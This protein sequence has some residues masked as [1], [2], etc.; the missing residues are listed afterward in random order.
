MQNLGQDRDWRRLF[1]G[2]APSAIEWATLAVGLVLTLRYRWLL[3]DAF[4]YFRYIDNLLFLKIGLVYNQGEFVE[5]F[6]SPLWMLTLL[7]GR[8]LH[9][10]FWY[11]VQGLG[12]ALV[13]LGW[14]LLMRLNRRMLSGGG[15]GS[16]RPRVGQAVLNLPLLYLAPNYAVMSYFTSGLETPLVQLAAVSYALFILEPRSKLLTWVVALSPLIRHELALPWMVFFAWVWFREKRFP[17][18]LVVTSMAVV[19]SWMGFRIWYYA[20]LFPNTFY[21]KN[22]VDPGQGWVYLHDTLGTYFFYP[23]FGLMAVVLIFLS[24]RAKSAADLGLA[25]RAMMLL[26]AASVAFF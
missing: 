24:R 11:L 22:V 2:V 6:S 13:A 16:S 1:G 3:D 17:L 10:D 21:L 15:S 12:C 9:L 8:V 19:G 5:G 23:I 25:A 7:V 26:V 20:D 4:V 18:R 14:R